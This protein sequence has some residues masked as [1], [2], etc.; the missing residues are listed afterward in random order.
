MATATWTPNANGNWGTAADWSTGVLPGA[1]DTATLAS[2]AA[3]TVTYS[4]G[5]DTVTSIVATTDRL[6][7][8]G[9]SLSVTKTASFGAGLSITAG[10]L[11]F[12]G[13]T[14]VA[15]LFAETG[16]SIALAAGT[17]LTLAGAATVAA[18]LISGTGTLATTGTTALTSSTVGGLISLDSGLT[19]NNSGTV[20]DAASLFLSFPSGVGTITITN[21]ATGVFNLTTNGAAIYNDGATALFANA[22]TLSK[23]AGTGT[24]TIDS[25]VTNTGTLTTTNGVLELDGGGILGGTIGATGTGALAFGDG[26]FTVGDNAQTITGALLLDGGSVSIA[27][28]RSLTLSGAV[29]ITSSEVNGPGTLVTTGKTS[30]TGL[31]DLDGSLSWTNGGTVSDL[32]EIQLNYPSGAGAITITNTTTGVFDLTQDG[33]GVYDD[34]GAA[35]FINAGTLSKTSGT[36]TSNIYAAVDNT[37]TLTAVSGTLELDGGGIL[38]GTIGAGKNGALALGGG[39]FTLGGTTQTITGVLSWDGT[40]AVIASGDTLTLAGTSTL[41]S[42][43]IIGPGTLM[44]TG[45]T[46]LVTPIALDGSLVWINTGTVLATGQLDLDFLSFAGVIAITNAAQGT[47]DLGGDG[48]AI[49]DYGTGATFTNAGVLAKTAGTGTTALG[50]AVDNTGTLT[51]ATGTLELDGGGSFAGTVGATGAGT[52]ALGTG[53]FTQ[54][55]AAQTI[56][57]PLLL[58]GGTLFIDSGQTLTL[59]GAVS[60]SSGAVT[61]AGTLAITN[62][63]TATGSGQTVA[64]TVS[65]RG[66]IDIETGTVLALDGGMTGTGHVTIEAGATLDVGGSL[67]S[68]QTI[69]FAGTAATLKLD[70][71]ASF[72]TALKGFGVGDSIDLA[73]VTLTGGTIS[74]KTLTL[75][76]GTTSYTYVAATTLAA[77]RAQLLSDGAGGAL[78]TLYAVAQAAVHTPQP[79]VFAHVHVGDVATETLTVTNESAVSPYTEVLDA[80]LSAVTTGFTTAGSITGLVAGAANS[81][82]LTITETTSTAGARSGSAKLGLDTDGTGVD[83]LAALAL[84]SQTVTMSGAVYAYAAPS[85]SASNLTLVARVGGSLTGDVT[86]SDGSIPTPYQESLVFAASG[87]QAV[88]IKGAGGTIAS[89]GSSLLGVTLASTVAGTI[90]GDTVTIGLTS[91]GVGTSGLADTALASQTV[92]VDAEVYALAVAKLSATTVNVGIVHVGDVVT[93]S[94]TVTNAGTGALVDSLTAGTSTTQGGITSATVTLGTGGLAAGTSGTI[95]LGIATTAAGTIS[96]SETLGFTSHDSALADQGITGGT[97]TVTGTVDHYAVAQVET[98]SGSGTLTKTTS[99]AYVLTLGTVTQNGTALTADL[100]ILNAAV[101]PADTLGG[102]LTASGAAAFANTGLTAFSGVAAGQ[103]DTAPVIT[104]STAAAGTFTETIILAPTGANASGYSG[105]L[106]NE[107]ITVTGTVEAAVAGTAYTLTTAAKI[108]TGTSGNDIINAAT[109]TLVTRDSIDGGGGTNT[110]NLTGAG[111]FDL[112]TPKTLADIQAVTAS[113]TTAGTTVTMRAGLNVTLTVAAHGSGSITIHGAADSD[114][115]NLGAATDTV[116]LGAVT[117]TVHGGGGTALIQATAAQ[118][119]AIVTGTTAGTTTLEV[120]TGGT[121]ALN[122][123]DTHLIVKLDAATNLGLGTAS[124]IATT[125]TAASFA[126]DTIAGFRGGDTI[127]LTDLVFATFKSLAYS[128][129]TSAGKLVVTDGSHSAT[130]TLTGNYVL[131]DFSHVSDG[132]GGT[133]IGFV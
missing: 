124:F 5:T 48:N 123:A 60:L 92:T 130:V 105:V 63:L 73:G 78:V 70:T 127:D 81:T 43:A 67:G 51:T 3:H 125:G 44:T 104:L 69:T 102:S 54:A 87:P 100:G 108:I 106:A 38:G 47:V 22:G 26:T 11:A 114:L 36:G 20:A 76:E 122:A 126:S 23:T 85:L 94:I 83:G 115:Y 18:G 120:T 9:G 68:G 79:V 27:Q 50:I 74:G 118:A 110:L 75:R 24:T 93:R 117:E 39:T 72:G 15:T 116:V 16:G 61:G 52:L 84:P 29:A 71:P 6:A 131:A 30:I 10:A 46:A 57:G 28:G 12:A 8:T 56:S 2:T 86:L 113:E 59:S 21:T 133:L 129:T 42:G 35:T 99:K 7:V 13:N 91:T 62:S 80:S 109:N 101:G 53:T 19:W 107:T 17:T 119:G 128:G 1:A 98:V 66:T 111:S 45:T 77:D 90:T 34:M 31:F 41:S 25:S 40:T 64:A 97:I 89:G 4:T 82:A 65:N 49:V 55:S 37:G 95:Q 32:G 112:A 88:T 33:W 96:G 58:D 103:A 14:S 121:A 132:H